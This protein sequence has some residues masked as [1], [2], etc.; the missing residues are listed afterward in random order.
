MTPR[1]FTTFVAISVGTS[2][3]IAVLMAVMG[4]TVN[5]PGWA[6]LVPIVMWAPALGSLI[7][8]RMER[9]RFDATLPLRR[10]GSTGSQVILLPVAMPLLVYG[11]AYAIAWM[12]G[13]RT[14]EPGRPG[15]GRPDRQI[16]VKPPDQSLHPRRVFGT[17]TAMGEEIGWR[18][19]LQPRLDA[20]GIRRSVAVVG[21]AWAA[22]H[23]PLIIGAGYAEA[24][25][26]W[27]KHWHCRRRSICRSRLSSW[28]TDRTGQTACGQQSSSTAFTTR[29]RSGC[30]RSSSRW[31]H[32]ATV[33]ER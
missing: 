33:A 28:R 8:R 14:L 32:R 5:S 26:L 19:Y 1:P 17:F 16:A 25:S 12:H 23:T 4:W 27:R 22:F 18:G 11:A 2:A 31:R 13:L 15:G 3:A 29:F 7:A 21:L 30:S 6:G 20:A 10:W 24:G 9:P